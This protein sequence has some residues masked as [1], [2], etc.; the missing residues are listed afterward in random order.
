[1]SELPNVAG[2]SCCTAGG[3]ALAPFCRAWRYASIA[4][5]SAALRV[6]FHTT[7]P[8]SLVTFLGFLFLHLQ[9]Y[10]LL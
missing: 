6:S 7:A 3:V 4:G 9:T 2:H 10:L 1:M 8:E 5:Q